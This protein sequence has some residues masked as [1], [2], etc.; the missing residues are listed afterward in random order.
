[1]LHPTE[2]RRGEAASACAPACA[3]AAVCLPACLGDRESITQLALSLAPIDLHR[4]F[5]HYCFPLIYTKREKHFPLND[6]AEREL[7]PLASILSR[8]FY[9]YDTEAQSSAFHNLSKHASEQRML[10]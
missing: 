8:A 7:L 1:M 9:V 3:A 10:K 2:T 5:N 4:Q 6:C